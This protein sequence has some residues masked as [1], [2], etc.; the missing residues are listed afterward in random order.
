MCLLHR[1]LI[2]I[3]FVTSEHILPEFNALKILVFIILNVLM[4]NIYYV[5]KWMDYF[6][7]NINATI[8]VARVFKNMLLLH[9]VIRTNRST[10]YHVALN[11]RK[12]LLMWK[13]QFRE[14]SVSRKCEWTTIL[15]KV[16]IQIVFLFIKVYESL[17]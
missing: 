7:F 16:S 4:E 6:V 5:H 9:N 3:H 13:L 17:I 15:V 12:R 1:F 11:H 2:Y 8:T 10:Y 14:I